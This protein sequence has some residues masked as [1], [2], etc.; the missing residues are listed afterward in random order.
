M[1]QAHSRQEHQGGLSVPATTPRYVL[2]STPTSPYGRKVRIAADVLG[3]ADRIDRQDADTLD[4]NDTLRRQNPLG[5]MPCLILDDGTA[6][7]DSRV[8]IEF[9]QDEA[10]TDRLLPLKGRA[11]FAM[12]TRAALADGLTDAALLMIYES[13]FR[14]SGAPNTRWLDHQRGK[15]MRALAAFEQDTPDTATTIATIGL[16]C[17]LGYLDWRRP[18][19]W[20]D[21]HPRLAAWLGRFDAGEPAWQRSR[22]PRA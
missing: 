7:Y 14:E 12:L 1:G 19:T 17:A 4:A 2:R 10:G 8:I 6:L 18:V 20:R 11:R 22:A 21:D 5:K 13:R 3:L 9:L 15:V 16:A